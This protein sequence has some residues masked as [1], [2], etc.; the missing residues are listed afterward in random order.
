[1]CKQLRY[2]LTKTNLH[3]PVRS[4]PKPSFHSIPLSAHS[5]IDVRAARRWIENL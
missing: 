5:L 2:T 1:M 4:R 3:G